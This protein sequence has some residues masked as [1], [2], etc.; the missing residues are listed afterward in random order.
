MPQGSP[1]EDIWLPHPS[2]AAT[3]TT[4]AG[5]S[6]SGLGAHSDCHMPC[7]HWATP[8]TALHTL[9]TTVH[10][11]GTKVHTL[12]TTVH[13][14]GTT[15]HKVRCAYSAQSE[16]YLGAALHR[17]F[18]ACTH[19]LLHAPH[20]H[21]QSKHHIHYN[22]HHT[23]I[24]ITITT[25]PLCCGD[26]STGSATWIRPCTR[27][28]HCNACHLRLRLTTCSNTLPAPC[29]S[30]L[31]S[32]WRHMRP[33][34]QQAVN[35]LLLYVYEPPLCNACLSSASCHQA[36]ASTT[37]WHGFICSAPFCAEQH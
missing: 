24:I 21:H 3:A 1:G 27:L 23:T 5:L 7:L 31:H 10:T 16:V 17:S 12:G 18:P 20:R 35:L 30:M 6:G 8:S 36:M 26:R 37:S 11:L 32:P 2:L 22:S 29:T 25:T 34:I 13:T 4:N 14:L 28:D 19:C 15:A 33:L 9:G